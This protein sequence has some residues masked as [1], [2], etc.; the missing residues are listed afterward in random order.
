MEKNLAISGFLSNQ[1]QN[2]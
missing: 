1:L 2:D